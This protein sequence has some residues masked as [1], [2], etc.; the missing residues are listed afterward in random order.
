M[1]AT[2]SE[3]LSI[4]RIDRDLYRAPAE[5]GERGLAYG[6][7]I[8][9][10]ALAAAGDSVDPERLPH[11]LHGYFL[12][13]GDGTRSTV[14]RVDRDRDG[15]S[16]SGRRVVV[17]QEGEVIFSMSASFQV[18][19]PGDERQLAPAPAAARPDELE[20]HALWLTLS[21]HLDAR[22]PEQPFENAAL[23][24]RLWLRTRDKLADEPLVHACA[25]TYMS[26]V[27]NGLAGLSSGPFSG[28]TSLDH[29]MWFHHEF[30]ADEW[31]LM[32][33]VPNRVASG[34]G[35]Y[36]GTFHTADGMLGATLAQES[37]VRLS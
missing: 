35:L 7:L 30:R 21:A 22:V 36:S 18:P 8:A 28:G 20:P 23:P 32:D 3:L 15:R 11:S 10:Q 1:T 33:L 34:R 26:D 12:R 19:R 25:L 16:F 14:L 2:L 4:E 37:L 31:V 17:L 9:A 24:T 13:G 6:G 5:N 27:S 29:A